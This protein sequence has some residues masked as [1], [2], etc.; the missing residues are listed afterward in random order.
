MSENRTGAWQPPSRPEWLERVNA[1]CDCPNRM[2]LRNEEVVPYSGPQ[3]R[4]CAQFA[5][6]GTPFRPETETPSPSY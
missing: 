1:R 6:I 3:V 5:E 4:S 2:T